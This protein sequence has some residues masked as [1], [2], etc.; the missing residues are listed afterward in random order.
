MAESQ[1]KPRWLARTVRD[2]I[3]WFAFL[4]A[5]VALAARF[6]PVVNH[7]VLGLAA[8]S[9]YLSLGTGLSALFLVWNRRRGA[10][11]LALA[12]LAVA[13]G[14]QVPRFLGSD[15]S[16]HDTVAVRVLTANL[17][18]GMADPR[19]VAAIARENADLLIVQELTEDCAAA[20]QELTPD[21]PHRAVESRAGGAG[22]GIWSRYPLRQS[23]RFGGYELGVLPAEVQVP[24]AA[25]EAV[26]L[27]THLV[28]PW[29]QPID[30][31]R[32]EIANLPT[33]LRTVAQSAGDGAVI[34][35]GD[36]NATADMAPFRRLLENGYRDAAAQAGAGLNRTF[37]AD[38]AVPP[39]IGIDHI[40][41]RNSS[42]SDVRTITIP[43]SDHL[44]VSA[45]IR[46]PG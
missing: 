22:V 25:S 37:P 13:V 17:R 4:V 39:L 27:A 42:A 24:G 20:L 21:F 1:V 45:T 31:W 34:V 23:S 29:P 32:R 38:A 41:T 40:L 30:G 3:A 44:G 28:G 12:V 19:A 26:V 8:L 2:L 46:I 35:A 15:G 11:L 14:I 33:T 10:T 43:G 5:A 7:T 16:S 9:P 6:A 36:L 18:E